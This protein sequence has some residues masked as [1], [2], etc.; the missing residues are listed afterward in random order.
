MNTDAPSVRQDHTTRTIII[1][2]VVIGVLALLLYA[3]SSPKQAPLIQDAKHEVKDLGSDAK[4]GVNDAYD[5]TKD[6]AHDAGATIKKGAN[7][8]WD[9]TKDAAED[10][11]AAIK[12]ATN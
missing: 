11:K 9:A 3:F 5:A 2:V 12:K 8:A 1:A 4:R 6:A 7:E 10:A